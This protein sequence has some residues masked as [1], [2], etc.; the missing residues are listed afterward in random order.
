MAVDVPGLNSDLDEY[1]EIKFCDVNSDTNFVV[2]IE[3]VSQEFYQE[4]YNIIDVAVTSDYPV[5]HNFDLTNGVLKVEC[6]KE[7]PIF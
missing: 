5:I 7:A 6:L 1:G 2:V 3:E 4:I